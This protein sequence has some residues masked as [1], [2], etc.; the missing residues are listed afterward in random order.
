MYRIFISHASAELGEANAL[1]RRGRMLANGIFLGAHIVRTGPLG[2]AAL[3]QAIKDCDA[4]VFA[5]SKSWP[6][7]YKT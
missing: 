2:I 3:K 1:V 5:T 7:Y 6:T 4:V